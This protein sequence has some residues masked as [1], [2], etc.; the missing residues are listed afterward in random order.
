MSQNDPKQTPGHRKRSTVL[1]LGI[2]AGSN[3]AYQHHK[4]G[5]GPKFH[6]AYSSSDFG[7]TQSDSCWLRTPQPS[8][9]QF[10][11]ERGRREASHLTNARV[12]VL[13]LL[14]LQLKVCVSTTFR[15]L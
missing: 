7:G 11:W 6:W 3:C 5:E 15:I 4:R 12:L 14:A 13:W 9:I 8:G 2:S 10:V 1:G